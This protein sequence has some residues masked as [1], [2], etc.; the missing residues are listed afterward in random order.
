VVSSRPASATSITASASRAIRNP[1]T[2]AHRACFPP[3]YG[4][5]TLI[6]G[7]F[8]PVTRGYTFRK[9]IFARKP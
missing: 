6:F 3:V 4:Q 2:H 9:A 8:L 1:F 5:K 7:S